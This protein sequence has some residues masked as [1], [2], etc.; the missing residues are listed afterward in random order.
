MVTTMNRESI[1]SDKQG[2]KLTASTARPGA[3][4]A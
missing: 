1:I 3:S 4:G 2:D